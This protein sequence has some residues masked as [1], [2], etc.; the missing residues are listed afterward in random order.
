MEN[1]QTVGF[2][3]AGLVTL[4][5]AGWVYVSFQN[6]KT[7]EQIQEGR[8]SA[9][10]GERGERIQDSGF[11]IQE[12]KQKQTLTDVRPLYPL[13]IGSA[14]VRVELAQT[15]EEK[16]QGLSG[17]Q[18]LAPETGMLFVFSTP[19]RYKFWMKEMLFPIDILW[20]DAKGTI[21]DFRRSLSPDTYP[22]IFEP[23]VE[24]QYV[25]ELPSRTVD[26]MSIK[27]G[28]SLDLSALPIK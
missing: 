17:R 12:E 22:A 4:I 7:G 26:A 27:R 23:S 1:K 25:L 20:I 11:K 14:T 24:A 15:D 13:R 10:T 19:E 8:Q 16:E 3:I 2:F 21:V 9:G 28:D 5:V 6:T 18:S